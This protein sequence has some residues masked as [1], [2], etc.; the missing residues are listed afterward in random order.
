MKSRIAMMAISLVLLSSSSASAAPLQGTFTFTGLVGQMNTTSMLTA[1]LFTFQN[2]SVTSAGTGDF[3]GIGVGTIFN[4]Q[5]VGPRTGALSIAPP[6]PVS[7]SG[8]QIT[9]PS[10]GTF[11]ASDVPNNI[12]LFQLPQTITLQLSGVF[13]P[14][15]TLGSF[16]PTPGTILAT[17]TRIGT[18]RN[19][20]STF[21]ITVPEPSTYALGAVSTCLAGA[22]ARRK[23]RM[24][25]NLA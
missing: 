16:S 11:V 4:G 14:S 19:I 13:T 20:N 22:L 5:V 1:T 7:M 9:N 6:A 24:A 3:S 8:F 17:F 18:S 21:A 25:S 23:R 10:F 12:I 15:G 2:Y